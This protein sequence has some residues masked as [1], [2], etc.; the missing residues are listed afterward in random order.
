MFEV[1]SAFWTSVALFLGAGLVILLI[2][3]YN[4]LVAQRQN[5]K[6]GVAD[7]D[8]QLRQR[9]DLIPNLVETVKGYAG[10]ERETLDAVISARN[11]AV[12]A[13]DTPAAQAQADGELSGML[14]RL[15]ALG[16]RANPPPEP[17]RRQAARYLSALRL[18][19][20]DRALF[21]S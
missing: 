12:A 1:A 17:S 2:V 18:I 10:H 20:T 16:V 21:A 5:V 9:H 15:F 19:A 4:R 7:I 13:P 14:Q 6:Q 8:A 11:A 3:I